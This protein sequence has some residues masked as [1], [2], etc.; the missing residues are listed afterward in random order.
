[1]EEGKSIYEFIA[2]QY[3]GA[4]PA[5]GMPGWLI[6]DDNGGWKRT[7][8]RSKITTDDYVNVGSALPKMFGSIT[9]TF[10]YKGF[11][12]SFMFY[13]SYGAKFSDY[14]YKE[15][16]TNRP[17]IGM[18]QSLIQD[19]WRNPGDVNTTLPR[20]SYSQYA[21]TVQYADNFVFD[22][23]YWRLRNFTLGYTL[24]KTLTRKALVEGL[25]IYVTGN[26]LLTFGPA[27]KRLTDPE[28]GV[29]G[30]SYNGN[31]DTDN[32]IQGSRRIYMTGIQLTF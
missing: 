16:I 22:N 29:S 21:A 20:W 1:M 25:R 27:A 6:R 8:D 32:G 5:T 12:L 3:D 15:R 11:D 4:D 24:P 9:N 31:G 14:S 26:N 18:V 7:E 13:Y 30:N 10:Q 19:R 2:P 17:G 28:T 23:H